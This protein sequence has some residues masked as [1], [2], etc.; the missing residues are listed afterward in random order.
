MLAAL[1]SAASGATQFEVETARKG[2]LIEVRARATLSAPLAVV[3]GTLVDYE[4]MPEFIPSMK[5]SRIV[6]RN[7]PISTIE[8]SGEARF[9]FFSYPIDVTIEVTDRSP[10]LEARRIAGNLRH[11]QGRYETELLPG[12]AQVQLRWTGAIAPDYELPP[13]IGEVIMRMLIREQFEGMVREIER[14]ESVRRQNPGAA[15]K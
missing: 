11:F 4:R 1:A 12:S 5:K 7:G 13:L 3:W 14:R 9:L 6:A 10:V 8:Q 2:D 15:T